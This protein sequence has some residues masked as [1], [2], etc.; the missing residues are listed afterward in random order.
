M[1][2]KFNYDELMKEKPEELFE[3]RRCRQLVDEWVPGWE[4]VLYGTGEKWVKKAICNKCVL[5]LDEAGGRISES[6]ENEIKRIK[7]IQSGEAFRNDILKKW[8]FGAKG[9]QMDGRNKKY[10]TY[11]RASGGNIMNNY[12]LNL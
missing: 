12:V 9:L 8:K 1:K 5:S 2:N 10:F 3:C 7:I 11:F 6:K 4:W